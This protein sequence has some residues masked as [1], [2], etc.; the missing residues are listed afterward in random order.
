[1]DLNSIA[2]QLLREFQ[3]KDDQTLWAALLFVRGQIRLEESPP[4]LPI[5]QPLRHCLLHGSGTRRQLAACFK[6]KSARNQKTA[7]LGEVIMQ[8]YDGKINLCLLAWGF[9][10]FCDGRASSSA[11]VPTTHALR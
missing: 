5:F 11:L 2:Q 4:Q 3:G 9:A 6:L 8:S 7:A 1:M 10:A